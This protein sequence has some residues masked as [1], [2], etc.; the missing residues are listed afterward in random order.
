MQRR[1]ETG[2][3]YAVK[4][5]HVRFVQGQTVGPKEDTTQRRLSGEPLERR[6]SGYGVVRIL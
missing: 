5:V 1:A 3:S 6:A 4:D 2:R